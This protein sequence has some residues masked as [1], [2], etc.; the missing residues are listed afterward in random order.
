[1]RKLFLLILFITAI[2]N[3]KSMAQSYV[4]LEEIIVTGHYP[5]GMSY[6]DIQSMI[7]NINYYYSNNNGPN[8]NTGYG[9]DNNGGSVD[10]CGVCRA[11]GES[12]CEPDPQPIDCANVVNGG[13]V[14]TQECGCIGGTT[15]IEVCPPMCQNS[16]FTPGNATIQ[17]GI[18]RTIPSSYWGFTFPELMEIDIDVCKEG[19]VW[20]AV[21]KTANGRYSQTARLKLGIMEVSNTVAINYCQQVTDLR[22]GDIGGAPVQTWYMLSAV[23][24]HENVHLSRFLPGLSDV[25]ANIETLIESVTIPYSGETETAAK[26]LLKNTATYQEA[27]TAAYTLWLNR[28]TFLISGDHHILPPLGPAYVAE[29]NITIPVANSICNQGIANGWP[30]CNSCQ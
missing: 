21:L 8:G 22:N 15:G 5:S 6:W 1:M 29:R 13:A 30:A 10:M 16:A 12:P 23:Q 19:G 18:S 27:V 9:C 3:K 14:W 20:K 26:A 28:C 4:M 7:N 11:V 25:V 24:A 17:G 2:E